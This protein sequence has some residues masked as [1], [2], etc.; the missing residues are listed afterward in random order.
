MSID[1]DEAGNLVIRATGEDTE[2]KYGQPRGVILVNVDG[3]IIEA[4]EKDGKIHT[5]HRDLPREKFP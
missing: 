5:N 3:T 4:W 2:W 1:T